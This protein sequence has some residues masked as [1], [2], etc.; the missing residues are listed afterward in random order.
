[1]EVNGRHWSVIGCRSVCRGT[2]E[3]SPRAGATNAV[4]IT[5]RNIFFY[6]LGSFG[7]GVFSTV[8]AVLLL[9]YCTNVMHLPALWATTIVFVPKAWAI[10]WDPFVGA[11]SDR[12]SGPFGRRR[13]FLAVGAAGV[14]AAF[15][16]LFSPPQFST[17]PVIA[18][19]I[20]AAYFALATLYSLFAVPYIAI[21]PE[22]GFDAAE[23]AR[24]VRSRMFVAMIGVL[25]GAGLAPLL[26]SGGGGGRAGYTVM[27]AVLASA[28]CICM[29]APLWMLRKFDAPRHTQR[30]ASEPSIGRQLRSV[31]GCRR[32]I[33][34][35]SSYL[36]MLAA[37]GAVTAAAPYLI[38]QVLGRAERDVG[39]AL[40]AML[41]VTT[42][43][44]PAWSALGRR[45]GEHAVLA[46][47][48]VAYAMLSV[49]LGLNA[50]ANPS[51]TASLA[52]FAVLGAPFAAAQVLPFTLLAHL[53]HDEVAN[54]GGAE[55]VLTGVWTAAE[56]IGLALGPSLV[57]IALAIGGQARVAIAPFIA[58]VPALLAL[59]AL[60]LLYLARSPSNDAPYVCHAHQ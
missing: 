58:I 5:H 47:A 10:L 56:K 26:V 44:I 46:A 29:A 17:L 34:L 18:T 2:G 45:F 16:A 30:T 32:F 43:T 53:I 28:C 22:I 4:R 21:P 14:A 57:G 9:Y 37:I 23:R 19:W 59:A 55:G 51:W 38:I 40:G 25:A 8:P 39:M 11:W 13:P 1:M 41:I 3:P 54:R 7:T 20:G 50:R 12:A 60:V 27:A 6:S 33:W 31:F 15:F 48:L 52:I 49:A 24:L 36:A 42:S 35:G